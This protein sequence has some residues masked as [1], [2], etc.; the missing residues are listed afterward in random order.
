MF[1]A[2]CDAQE[3]EI[4][5]DPDHEGVG[6]ML[7]NSYDGISVPLVS[8]E[9]VL[10]RYNSDLDNS[11]TLKMD[12]EGCEYVSILSSP[13]YTL[14]KFGHIMIEYHY[15]YRDLK[16]KL[17]EC[18]FEVSVTR[19]RVYA[20]DSV[21]LQEEYLLARKCL[22]RINVSNSSNKDSGRCGN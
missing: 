4:F 14:Q 16:Y 5:V 15:G 3:G 12:C 17:E 22:C 19:P 11:V 1:L 2:G 21:K 7:K 9:Q 6:C 18:G 13:K 8:L 10:K 20:W